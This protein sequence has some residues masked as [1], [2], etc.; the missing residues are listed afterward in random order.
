MQCDETTIQH[1]RKDLEEARKTLSVSSQKEEAANDIIQSLRLE[2]LQLKRRLREDQEASNPHSH[3]GAS[4]ASVHLEAD[5]QVKRMMNK[6]GVRLEAESIRD[7]NIIQDK[8]RPTNFQEWK[9]KKFLWAPDTP[10]GSMHH[11][12]QV[13]SIAINT[14]TQL[15]VLSTRM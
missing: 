2:I 15:F 10:G 11:D 5:N 13:I 9:M 14:F 6:R 3:I 7:P 12:E 8:D 4:L 1:L